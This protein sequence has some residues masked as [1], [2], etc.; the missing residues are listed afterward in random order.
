MLR[1]HAHD[2]EKRAS[3]KL[4]LTQAARAGALLRAGPPAARC[5]GRATGR[6]RTGT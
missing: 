3:A 2:C 5:A 6:G 1:A 4:A